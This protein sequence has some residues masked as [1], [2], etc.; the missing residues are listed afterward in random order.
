MGGAGICVKKM[1]KICQKNVENTK[2][3]LQCAN[4]KEGFDRRQGQSL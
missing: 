3:L 4:V 1:L 2:S